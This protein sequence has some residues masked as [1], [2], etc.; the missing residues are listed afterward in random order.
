MAMPTSGSP[1]TTLAYQ[2]E[3]NPSASA[4]SACATTLSTVDP[5][6]VSPMRTLP[7]PCS[8]RLP[9]DRT[10]P[11]GRTKPGTGGG[12]M[13]DDGDLAQLRDEVRYLMDRTA[14]ADCIAA[15]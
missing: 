9:Y 11:Y 5:P 6:P 12:G 1:V 4:R 13:V 2:S 15:H 7:L 10:M 3:V 14:I 8:T